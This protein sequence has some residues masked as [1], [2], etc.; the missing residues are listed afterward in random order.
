MSDSEQCLHRLKLD[1]ISLLVNF[2]C[3]LKQIVIQVQ[4]A[5]PIKTIHL[6][7]ESAFIMQVV[8]KIYYNDKLFFGNISQWFYK[9]QI[10]CLG[11]LVK[12]GTLY[13]YMYYVDNFTTVCLNQMLLFLKRLYI[14]S[15][16]G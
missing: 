5:L 7:D 4:W 12:Q 1:L 13:T 8:L 2:S 14:T 15:D 16:T 9:H 10:S 3:E 11:G 6:P